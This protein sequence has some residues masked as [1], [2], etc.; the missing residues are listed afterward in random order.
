MLGLPRP[1]PPAEI[2]EAALA[3]AALH[4]AHAAEV[5]H[6]PDLGRDGRE[7]NQ[8]IAAQP[9]VRKRHSII[10]EIPTRQTLFIMPSVDWLVSNILKA[11][12]AINMHVV[13][14]MVNA[15]G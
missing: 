2:Y 13:V 15:I 12:I 9:A 3:R 8:R 11:N 4:K 10:S 14:G 7:L 6:Q 1:R 5:S